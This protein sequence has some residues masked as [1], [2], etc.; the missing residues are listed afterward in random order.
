MPSAR[1]RLA[2]TSTDKGASITSSHTTAATAP[3]MSVQSNAISSNT[4]AGRS[5]N[6]SLYGLPCSLSWLRRSA[7]SARTSEVGAI[8]TLLLT[9]LCRVAP[10]GKSS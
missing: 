8:W 3:T 1:C 4:R 10:G 5:L 7:M 9:V 2:S 6:N